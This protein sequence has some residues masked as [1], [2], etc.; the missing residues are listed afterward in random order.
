MNRLG[1]LAALV[2]GI[3]L[4]FFSGPRAVGAGLTLVEAG[5]GPRKVLRYRPKFGTPERSTMTM[6]LSM[7]G[8]ISTEARGDL[9]W[10]LMGTVGDGF[11]VSIDQK[12]TSQVVPEPK[13][14]TKPPPPTSLHLKAK[15]TY[16][17]RGRVSDIQFE[18]VKGAEGLPMQFLDELRKGLEQV[19]VPWLPAEAVGAGARWVVRE[20][21]VLFGLQVLGSTVFELRSLEGD[22]LDVAYKTTFTAAPGEFQLP[23]LPK[24]VQVDVLAFEGS[25]EGTTSV[26][27]TRLAPTT[28]RSES[29][30]RVATR[31]RHAGRTS[32]T[33]MRLAL[34]MGLETP[35][36]PPPEAGTGDR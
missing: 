12:L 21:S 25:G 10:R 22:R 27:L 15:E 24:G 29:R 35:V 31:T 20:R 26:D 34:V 5:Q 4:A 6:R 1:F 13:S 17:S 30:V 3:G 33:D 19:S 23:G 7:E 2:A 28:S 11:V 18:S 9:E 32:T 8:A 36:A 16:S 14:K